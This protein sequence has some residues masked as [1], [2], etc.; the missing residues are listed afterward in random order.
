MDANSAFLNGLT[1]EEVYVE[2]PPGLKMKNILIMCINSIRCSTGLSK[3]LE[4]DMNALETFSLT[5]V[6]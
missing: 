6:L 5:M 4:H 3:H 2:Q 1:K